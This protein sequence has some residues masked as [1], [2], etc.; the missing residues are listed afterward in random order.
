M[1]PRESPHI[2]KEFLG[3]PARCPFTVSFCIGRVPLLKIDY[4]KKGTLILTT[5]LKDLVCRQI[6][7]WQECRRLF[8]Q[9]P[10]IVHWSKLTSPQ[11]DFVTF[12][13]PTS[14]WLVDMTSHHNDVHRTE[15][16]SLQ[17][18]D[19]HYKTRSHYRPPE[20]GRLLRSQSLVAP[21]HP[22][23]CS[24]LDPFSVSEFNPLR[25]KLLAGDRGQPRI[26]DGN[27][28]PTLQPVS[29]TTNKHQ[30]S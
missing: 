20:M 29:I 6:L 26:L 22:L 21:G 16:L 13:S 3:P 5:L 7:E 18:R 4:G 24:F 23:S 27:S 2:S 25:V 10:V 9:T 12:R 14:K 8:F 11:T 15:P 1:A 30:G 19:L 28:A 17:E